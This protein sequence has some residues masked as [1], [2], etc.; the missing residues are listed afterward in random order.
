MIKLYNTRLWESRI[1]SLD[2]FQA[3]WLF[4][5]ETRSISKDYCS[6]TPLIA[7]YIIPLSNK[8]ISNP[9]VADPVCYDVKSVQSEYHWLIKSSGLKG[10]FNLQISVELSVR[11]IG[12][13]LE[14]ISFLWKS[15]Y[16]GGLCAH[17][18]L[19]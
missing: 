14:I 15:V 9:V 18:K 2:L 19:S 3:F 11:Y 16:A 1:C 7:R 13:S 8:C 12:N 10:S 5:S 6:G 17:A 4:R